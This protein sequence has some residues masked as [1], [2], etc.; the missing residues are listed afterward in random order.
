[1]VNTIAF[2]NI[3]Y[4]V[5]VISSYDKALN[6]P[7]GCV[8]N[9]VM[10]VTS[11]PATVAVSLNKDNYTNSVI[12]NNGYFAVSVLTENVDPALI[13]C[14]GFN[15]GKNFF[16]YADYD[17][18]YAGETPYLVTGANA[19]IVCKVIDTMETSTHTVFLGEVT[20]ADVL[21]DAPS[22]TYAYYHKVLKGK[23]PKNAPT[24][25]KEE[26]PAASAS[27]LKCDICGYEYDES[28][29]GPMPDDY[30]CPICGADKSHFKKI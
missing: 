30:V 5:Y 14:F 15:S 2:R 24:Y 8:A 18:D 28:V 21:G 4:G 9:S 27:I 6:R 13:G 1:M 19:Y 29:S 20:A 16:K 7:T 12:K 3:S 11:S 22:L 17:A 10:Q 23:S 26:A 25:I